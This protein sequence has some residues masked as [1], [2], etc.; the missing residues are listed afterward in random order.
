MALPIVDQLHL[1]MV[2]ND[3]VC[4]RTECFKG[5]GE[6]SQNTS[7][8]YPFVRRNIGVET[9]RNIITGKFRKFSDV[10]SCNIPPNEGVEPR[11]ILILT[12]ITEVCDT[13]RVDEIRIQS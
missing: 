8:F 2:P 1:T 10:V 5:K 12:Q 13:L 11:S 9:F 6:E 3:L 4:V 7:R